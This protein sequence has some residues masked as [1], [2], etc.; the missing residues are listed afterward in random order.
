MELFYGKGLL[1]SMLTWDHIESLRDLTYHRTAKT[2]VSTIAQA[3]RFVN[4]VGF[5]F[6]FTAKNSEL[7]CL[8]HAA[9]GERHPPYPEHTHSDP[10]IGLVWQAKDD[11]ARDRSIYYG[12]AIKSRPSMI[13]LEFFPSF[14]RLLDRPA[15]PDQFLV[16]YQAGALSPA[17]RRIMEALCQRSPMVTFELKMNSSM[18]HPRKRSEFDRAMAELQMKMYVVKIDEFYD[19]FS[20]LWDLVSSRFQPEIEIARSLSLKAA[21]ENILRQYFRLRWVSDAAACR[22]LFN[23]PV[24][25]VQTLLDHLQQQDFLRQVKIENGR[26]EVYALA[27][28]PEP[29]PYRRPVVSSK[30][31]SRP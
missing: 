27:D 22:R 12:K 17:A 5:C 3:R 26:K 28:L 11:L 31:R 21:R 4:T 19:P 14:Y 18:S 24:E 8:W 6:A 7:P 16:D 20:F 15:S 13:S 29:S 9:C 23:W 1:A 2:R 30:K 25:V 10:A